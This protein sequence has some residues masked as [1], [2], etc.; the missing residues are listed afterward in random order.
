MYCTLQ[1]KDKK[2]LMKTAFKPQLR[3]LVFDIDMTDCKVSLRLRL[4]LNASLTPSSTPQTTASAPAVKTRPCASVAGAS[5][6]WRSRCS[7]RP[8]VVS[9]CLAPRPRPR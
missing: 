9:L 8:C 6:Q 5:S 7:T 1:P 4:L 2:V 3:E